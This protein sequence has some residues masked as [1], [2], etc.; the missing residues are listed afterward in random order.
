MKN[1]ILVF[2]FSVSSCLTLLA[3]QD[4]LRP[5]SRASDVQT[6]EFIRKVA[7]GGL[8]EMRLGQLAQQNGGSTRVR[9]FGKRM[10]SDHQQANDALK[11]FSQRLGYS[12][13][14]ERLTEKSQMNYD[15]LATLSGSEFDNEYTRQ[16]I[17]SHEETIEMFRLQAENGQ[18]EEVR[19]WARK[20]LPTLEQHLRQIR[21][22]QR[23][24]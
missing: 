4:S 11:E 12:E 14:P 23:N 10:A 8:S 6:R 1:L 21:T 22:W 3:Q 17:K 24:P 2:V 19:N 13:F 5:P 18:D 9:D 20:T 7:E 16:I 15:R